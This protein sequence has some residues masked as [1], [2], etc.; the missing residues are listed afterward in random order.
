MRIAVAGEVKGCGA[1]WDGHTLESL[2]LE[3]CAE[4]QAAHRCPVLTG[5]RALNRTGVLNADAIQILAVDAGVGIGKIHVVD[6]V[7]CLHEQLEAQT[8]MDGEVLR[9]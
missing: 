1:A 5:I 8:F 3:A 6:G 7:E 4:L 2:E 9:E